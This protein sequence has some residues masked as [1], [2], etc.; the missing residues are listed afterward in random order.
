MTTLTRPTQGGVLAQAERVYSFF[1]TVLSYIASS[2]ILFMMVMVCA[3]IG[4]RFFF[5]KPINGVAEIVA[6]LIVAA[7]FLQFGSTIRDGR[8]IRADFIMGRWHTKRPALARIAEIFFFSIGALALALAFQWLLR[9]LIAAYTSDE[10]TGAAGAY[11]ISLWPF[12]LGVV[13]GCGAALIECL[14][15][16]GHALSGLQWDASRS[17]ASGPS[18]KRDVLPILLFIAVV[19][20][21][22]L[23]NFNFGLSSVQVA[24]LSLVALVT[25]V[26]IG[27]PIAFALLGLSFVGIWLTRDN[28]TIAENA[29]GISASGTI[30][31]YEFGVVPLFV[32]MG[33]MLE[34]ADV[35]RDA[36]VISC[37]LLQRIRGGLGIATV[38]AN[39]IFASIT[40]SSMASAAV[41]SRIAVF[42]MVE[43][44]YTK[45]FAV[46]VVAG[47]SVLGMIIPPSILMIIYGLLAEVS[48]GKLFIAGILP[49]ILLALA[50]SVLNVVLATY[51]PRF[52]GVRKPIDLHL[53]SYRSIVTSLIP[54]I[55]VI[56]L[57]MGGIYLGVF[58]PTEAGAVGAMAAFIIG[59]VRRK[60]TF[61]VIR[62][63]ALETGYISAALLFPIISANF[64][65]RMLTLS[66][67]PVE[68]TSSITHL[69]VGMPTFLTVYFIV[70]LFLGMILDSVSIMLI[71]LP[72]VLPVVAALGAD[73]IWFGLITIVS[74]EIGLL[75]PPFGMSVFVVK[76]TLPQ[77]YV[78]LGDVFIGS[79]P[80]VVVMTLV[81]VIL[82]IFPKISLALL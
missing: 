25:A 40:G 53:M 24:I 71:M 48:I 44:G 77:G 57:V 35:G 72:I 31:S 38:V 61:T 15:V 32:I 56:L 34:K 17:E 45:R 6:N 70:I 47:S 22:F 41:F 3:D 11:I 28:F 37:A 9:D 49:G 81:T 78:T 50:Y 46:G 20:V 21:F 29:L 1:P 60:L 2:S 5:N 19:A 23:V 75:T 10:F 13:V 18:L 26:S 36:F 12:K 4:M 62:D 14:R 64:Y 82:M 68:L 74:I 80:F 67:L 65:A 39:A 52:T 76:G 7:V 54:I 51:F 55:C 43:S 30:R 58:T 42:P 66:G 27:M 59:L 79:A 16:I 8:L 69:D 33:L 73:P 63:V